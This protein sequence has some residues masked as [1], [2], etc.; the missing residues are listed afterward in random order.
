MKGNWTTDELIEFFTITPKDFELI[1]NKPGP[2]R[3]GF[4][5]LLKY[6]KQEARFPLNKSEIPQEIVKYIAKQLKTDPLIFRK[7]ELQ[8]R[9]YIY[10]RA[11]IRGYFNFS[12][13]SVED[14]NE[15]SEWLFKH[16][17]CYDREKVKLSALKRLRHIKL[18]PPTND[19]MDRII[20]SAI[21]RYENNLFSTIQNSLPSETL[22]LMGKTKHSVVNR[23]RIPK[24][25]I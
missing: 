6:F 22:L 25:M 9:T 4:S 17:P 18:V 8:G 20:S 14:A 15:L 16:V 3:L 11:Q 24:Y 21:K 2:T 5:V 10:H 23:H 1:A 13:T 19:R 12:E 7:Y